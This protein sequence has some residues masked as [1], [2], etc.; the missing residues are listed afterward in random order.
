MLF[1]HYKMAYRKSCTMDACTLGL[2]TPGRLEPGRQE[3]WNLDPC[4]FEIG[5]PERLITA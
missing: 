1:P 5:A 3:V 4:A 2:W